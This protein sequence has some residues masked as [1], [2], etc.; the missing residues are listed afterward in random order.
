M[1]FAIRHYRP[2]DAD[3]L[4]ELF[5]RAVH[6]GTAEAYSDRQRAAWAPEPPAGPAWST[7][8]A[9]AFTLVAETPEGPRGFMSL[10]P[11]GCVDLA[12]VLPEARGTGVAAALYRAVETE[13]RD[14][15]L[16][17]IWTDASHPARRFFLKQGWRVV[18]EQQPER[19]GVKLTNYR[20][21]KRLT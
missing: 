3:A 11:E 1:T 8:L 19:E 9:K 17:L 4:A 13:A 21:E 12:F 20:M 15:G 5:Y 18:A 7:R 2:G 10:T 16:S 14:R 6:E